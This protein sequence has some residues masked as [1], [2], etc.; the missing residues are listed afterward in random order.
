M[1]D[2]CLLTSELSELYRNLCKLKNGRTGSYISNFTEPG[3]RIAVI[4]N[5]EQYSF[6]VHFVFEMANGHLKSR[7]VC[8]VSTEQE[9]DVFLDELKALV[10]KYP[11]K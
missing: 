4:K 3:L 9:Y 11:E 2:A 5:E 1:E 10:E 8:S 6:A 7:K